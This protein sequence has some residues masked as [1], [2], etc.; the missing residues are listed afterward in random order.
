MNPVRSHRQLKNGLFISV[1]HVA[2]GRELFGGQVV[3]SPYYLNDDHPGGKHAAPSMVL[4]RSNRTN[5]ELTMH[6]SQL[7][8][9]RESDYERQ[10]FIIEP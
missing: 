3:G 10:T 1:R 5:E 8:I 4:L 6:L 7:G 2:G 9:G